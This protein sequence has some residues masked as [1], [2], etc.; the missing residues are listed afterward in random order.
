MTLEPDGR[1]RSVPPLVDL[2]EGLLAQDERE[3]GKTMRGVS[4]LIVDRVL[5]YL[6]EQ[7]VTIRADLNCEPCNI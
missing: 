5:A 6:R 2:V 3:G 1:D 4:A 7:G